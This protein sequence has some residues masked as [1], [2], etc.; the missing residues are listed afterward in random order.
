[1]RNKKNIFIICVV[2]TLLLV[3]ISLL[4]IKLKTYKVTIDNGISRYVEKVK[5]NSK[6]KKPV[7]PS[8]EGYEFVGWYKNG[9]LYNFDLTVKEDFTLKAKFKKNEKKKDED[10]KEEV[11]TEVEITTTTKKDDKITVTK[12]T[13]NNNSSNDYS[14]SNVPQTQGT[15][16]RATTTT[17]TTAATVTY[18]YRR[19]PI[20]TSTIGQERIY[21]VNNSTGSYVDGTV[22]ISYQ[23]GSVQN[24]SI[25]ASGKVVVGST[26][27]SISS[28]R[29]N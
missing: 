12:K 26:I 3:L 11:T 27:S 20:S 21:V 22:T 24:V 25:P 29:G 15:T 6:I 14:S 19:I 2:I 18:S 13:T 1:M 4:T 17:T 9:K 8:K 10:V 28:P 23:D 16:T 7:N 5:H